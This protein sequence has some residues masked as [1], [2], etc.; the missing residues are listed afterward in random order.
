MI[1]GCDVRDY[2]LHGLRDQV[3]YVLQDT[4]LFRGTILE[5]IAFGK[6]GATR[7]EIEAAARLRTNSSR[8]C[9]RATRP[10]LANVDL[11]S[12]AASGNESALPA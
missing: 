1:D 6:P 8:A 5:N 9:R 2:K 4:V 12:L 3:G 11:R 10:W 7:E